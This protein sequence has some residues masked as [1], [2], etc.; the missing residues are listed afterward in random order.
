[1]IDGGSCRNPSTIVHS[2]TGVAVEVVVK[3]AWNVYAGALLAV[4]AGLLMVG[5]VAALAG[6]ACVRGVTLDFA[7]VLSLAIV[8]V[9]AAH[10]LIHIIVAK[11][12]G[13]KGLRVTF[14]PRLLSVAVD[15]DYMSPGQYF[16]VALAP[17]GLSLLLLWLAHILLLDG[18]Y[19]GAVITYT[20]AVVN[21]VGGVPEVFLAAYF[22]TV[23]RNA[24]R[25]ALLYDEKGI[26]GGVVEEPG[27][28]VVYM[29]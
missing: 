28:L 6:F 13:V 18:V 8:G 7:A 2:F 12:L 14:I 1:M 3:R 11:L 24:R 19:A 15:Y 23:H 25:L 9:V 21:V 26:A 20:A 17:Q 22:S 10:E 16:A 5:P 29:F 27:R 4:I